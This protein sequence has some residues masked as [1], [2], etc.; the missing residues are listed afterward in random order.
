MTTAKAS[1]A[2]PYGF[3]GRLVTVEGD[4]CRGLPALNIVGMANRTIDES[5]DRIRSAIRNS[6]FIFPR[7]KVVINLAPAE[8]KKIGTSLDLPIAMVILAISGQLLQKD[9]SNKLFVGELSL[10]GTL[11]PVRGIINIIECAREHQIKQ[12]Y[13][14][15]ANAAQASLVARDIQIIPIDSLQEL[16]QSLKR[17]ITISPLERCV[18]NTQK[19]KHR[20]YYLDEIYGQFQAKRAMVIAVAGHHNIL[21]SGPPGTGKTMLAKTVPDLL[22]ELNYDEQISVTKLHSLGTDIQDIIRTRPFRSPH[23]TASLSAIIGGGSTAVPGEISLAHLGVLCLDELPEYPS[24]ILESLRQPL[25]DHQVTISR[26]AIKVTYPADFMLVGTMN[27]CPCGYL[28]SKTHACTCSGNQLQAYRKKL[29]GPVLDRID[30]TV[31]MTPVPQSQIFKNTTFSTREHTTA[32]TQIATAI[33]NQH[34]RYGQPEIYNASLSSAEIQKFLHISASAKNFLST[35]ATKLNLSVRAY[36][37]VIKVAQTIADIESSPEI[38]IS[39]LSEAL[40]Y[41]QTVAD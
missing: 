11:R 21:L 27:P 32:T 7:E 13:I 19:D 37:K 26:N 14:P 2:I 3:N 8:L 20:H 31:A 17:I 10:N 23:H 4:L 12:I 36:F 6:G 35:A 29:S 15:A 25:E 30:L 38:T 16:W 34:V 9:L 1:S 39:H 18:K 40:Q 22:P 41:R 24:R 28:G 5:K 33:A